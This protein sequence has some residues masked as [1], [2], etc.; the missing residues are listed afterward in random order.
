VQ[1]QAQAQPLQANVQVDEDVAAEV[2]RL[3]SHN[4]NITDILELRRSC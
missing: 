3:N 4:D 1:Q 2:S